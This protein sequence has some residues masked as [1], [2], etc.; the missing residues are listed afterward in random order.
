M[1][2][3]LYV[4]YNIS[5]SNDKI[6]VPIRAGQ[7]NCIKDKKITFFPKFLLY[8]SKD[9]G[10]LRAEYMSVSQKFLLNFSDS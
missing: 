5:K 1:S 2:V 4:R 6:G 8:T 9:D 3:R 10:P 7:D